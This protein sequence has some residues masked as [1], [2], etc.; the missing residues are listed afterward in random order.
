M[1]IVIQCEAKKLR[2]GKE[3]AKNYPSKYWKQLISMF[4][5]E[6]NI[7]QIGLEGD[8]QYTPDFRKGLS[9]KELSALVKECEFWISIDSFLQHLAWTLEK[10][11]IVLFGIS[12][13]NIF[14]HKENINLLK[15]RKNLRRL[16]FDIWENE[17]YNPNVFVKPDIVLKYINKIKHKEE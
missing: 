8:T 3:N 9:M 5:V 7:V 11:G 17:K 13:P 12:D 2:N 15:D 16:Q 10:P 1:L 4:P 14:G 6:W